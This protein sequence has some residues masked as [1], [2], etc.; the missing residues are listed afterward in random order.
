MGGK[1]ITVLSA[2]EPTPLAELEATIS[3]ILKESNMASGK[4]IK[5]FEELKTNKLSVEE[6]VQKGFVK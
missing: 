5:E 4:S 6:E 2:S 1:K 3:G